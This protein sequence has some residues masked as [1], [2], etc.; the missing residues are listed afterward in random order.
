[1]VNVSALRT[2]KPFSVTR[3]GIDLTTREAGLRAVRSGNLKQ[4]STRPI[5]LVSEQLAKLRPSCTGNV[6][7]KMAIPN[8]SLYVELFE[9]Y[10]SVAF[11]IGSRQLVQN[12]ISLPSHLSIN[13]TD[14]IDSFCSVFGSL[15][16]ARDGSLRSSKSSQRPFQVFGVCDDLAVRVGKKI[17]NSSVDRNNGISSR[18]WGGC[19]NFAPQ[20]CKPLVAVFGDRTGFR[21]ALDGPVQN[22]RDTPKFGESEFGPVQAPHFAM[23]LT[24]S[25]GIL[26]FSFE[27]RNLTKLFE[28]SLP[29]FVELNEQLFTDVPGNI[30]KPR[31]FR[32]PN[33]QRIN[34]IKGCEVVFR[35][36]LQASESLGMSMVPK[37]SQ[38]VFPRFQPGNLLSSW[39]D[40]ILERLVSD[41]FRSLLWGVSMSSDFIYEETK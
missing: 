27:L 6:S 23:G 22:Q 5:Q 26:P 21:L 9:D 2:A 36:S 20:T 34:L 40:A 35:L 11:G 7:G 10:R 28:T 15:L 39:I 8:H 4:C 13:T 17:G 32:T 14:S 3:I 30:G 41:H 1:M 29:S 33:S 24:D 25:K 37:P 38:R 16:S 19:F 18:S 12:V 31:V